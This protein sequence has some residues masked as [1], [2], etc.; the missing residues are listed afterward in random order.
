MRLRAVRFDF[1]TAGRIIFGAGSAARIE[2]LAAEFG[3]NPLYVTGRQ[4]PVMTVSS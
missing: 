2:E 4:Q 3:S 1:A